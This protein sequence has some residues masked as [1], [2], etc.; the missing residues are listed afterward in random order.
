M[1]FLQAS[2]AGYFP[3]TLL[4]TPH[5]SSPVFSIRWKVDLYKHLP[6]DFLLEDTCKRLEERKRVRLGYLSSTSVLWPH[7]TID[8][9]SLYIR[10]QFLSGGLFSSYLLHALGAMSSLYLFR[11]GDGNGPLLWRDTVLAFVGLGI[12]K[13]YLS[14]CKQFLY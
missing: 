8:N 13:F 11:W 4:S 9:L 7:M 3:F 1:A 14:F 10:S 12:L 5:H 6:F 2:C